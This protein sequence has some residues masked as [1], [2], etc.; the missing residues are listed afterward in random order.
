MILFINTLDFCYSV[1]DYIDNNERLYIFAKEYELD[2][3]GIKNK[4][5]VYIK[6][7]LK[8]NDFVVIISFHEANKKI[9]KLFK[10]DSDDY[11]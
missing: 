2:N 10:K 8:N 1:D 4:V 6:I 3:W 9:E 11:E 7:A 5:L